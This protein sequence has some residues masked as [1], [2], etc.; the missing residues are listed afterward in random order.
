MIERRAKCKSAARESLGQALSIFERLGAPLWTAKADREISRIAT[1]PPADGLT[2][3][4]RRIAALIARGHT[5]RE[6]A[7]T[8]FVT[9][10]TVQT[11]VRHIF[12]KLGIRSRTELAARLLPAVASPGKVRPDITDSGDSTLWR[13]HYR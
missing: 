9:E 5:N 11:H 2:E 13:R 8:M 6:V 1:R 12:Q 10:N 3:T 7:A 4:E